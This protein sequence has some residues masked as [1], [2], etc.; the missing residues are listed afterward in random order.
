[1]D[2][3]TTAPTSCEVRAVI[4]FLHAEGQSAT[5]IQ[6]WWCHVYGDNVMSERL[7]KLRRSIQIKRRGTLTK[8]VVLLRDNARP[9]TVA[10]TN[11]FNDSL[12][13]GDFRPPSLQSG[14]AAKRLP[15]LHQDEG[16]VGYPVLPHQR[17]A[18]GWSQQLC[19]IT[20]RHL[21]LTKDYKMTSA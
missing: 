11:T 2:T 14:P 20:W 17:R 18:H 5:E 12:Q 15:F 1:M 19:C 7:N 6:R 3:I 8:S 13:L 21:S 9:H 10:S 16:L 4:R